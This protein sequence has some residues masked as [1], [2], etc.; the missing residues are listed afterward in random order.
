MEDFKTILIALLV[1]VL[2]SIIAYLFRMRQLY[3][4]IPRLYNKSNLSTN[5]S[6]CEIKIYNRG[7][8]PEEEITV[9][10]A[11]E[12]TIELLATDNTELSVIDNKIQIPRLHK[13]KDSS[14][15]LMVEGGTFEHSKIT[16]FSSK[17]VTGRVLKNNEDTPPNFAIFFVC[18]A[19]LISFFP[20]FIYGMDFYTDY[21][22][23][24]QAALE[25][26]EL[27]NLYSAGWSKLGT[28]YNSPIRKS[29][30]GQEFPILLRDIYIDKDGAERLRIELINKTGLTME[31]YV[32]AQGHRDERDVRFEYW[33]SLEAEPLSKKIGSVKL[34][35]SNGSEPTLPIVFSIR[36]GDDYVHGVE[37]EIKRN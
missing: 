22:R 13:F 20:A 3:V 6:L 24:S 26:N 36:T 1:F 2:T 15:L 25:Q 19:A 35:K 23:S 11:P 14:A 32:D 31:I 16:T 34:P 33:T 7:N 17:S 4:S 5:G 12:L 9:S 10:F 37:Y 27:A 28:Y 18:I 8:H 29:Y 21:K 30:A